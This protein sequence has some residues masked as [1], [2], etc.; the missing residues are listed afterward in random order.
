VVIYREGRAD[1]SV[2]PRRALLPVVT[3]RACAGVSGDD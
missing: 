1:R 2:K 3:L